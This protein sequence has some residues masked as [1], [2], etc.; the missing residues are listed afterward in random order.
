MIRTF[1]LNP[2]LFALPLVALA[3]SDTT[4][5]GHSSQTT[6][7]LAA[8]PTPLVDTYST[9]PFA[10]KYEQRKRAFIRLTLANPAQRTA[11][12]LLRLSLDL[13]IDESTI[14]TDLD[15]ID[16]RNDSADFRLASVLRLAYAYMDSDALS[17]SL[18]N[19]VR[20]TI[21]GFKY[22]PDEPGVDNMAYQTE[23]H[24][25]LFASAGLLA[26]KLYPDE[27]FTNAGNLG[28]DR[29]AVYQARVLRWLTLRQQTGFSEWLSNDYYNADA[30]ALLNLIDFSNDPEIARKATMVLD[31]LMMDMAQ[32]Q[33]QGSFASTHG[34]AKKNERFSGFN[35]VT[36]SIMKLQFGVNRF[37]IAERTT[38]FFVLSDYRLPR[39]I[40]D[41]ANDRRP[42][43]TKQRMGIKIEEA[44]RWGLDYGR[45]EDGMTF[46]T[47]EAYAHPL[48]VELFYR[49]LYTY[50]WWD[51]A[52]F[53]AF[54]Q[55]KDLLDCCS[56]FA[57]PPVCAPVAGLCAAGLVGLASGFERDVTRTMR[58]E[59]N[60]YTHRTRDYMLSTAQ[61]WRAGFGGDQ[62]AIVMAS[63]GPEATVFT[64]HPA[65]LDKSNSAITPTYWTGYGTLPRSA[66]IKN[67]AIEIYDIST[68][69]GLYLPSQML[70]TAAFVP[71]GKFDQVVERGGWIFVRKGAGFLA[72]W[73]RQPYVWQTN[74]DDAEMGGMYEIVA[75]GQ[76]NIWI[77]EAD[78]VGRYRSF[79]EF[80]SAIL[81]ASLHAT[82]SAVS[83]DSP[84]QGLLQ[85][86]SAGPLTQRGAAVSVSNYDRYQSRFSY[87]AFPGETFEFRHGQDSLVLDFANQARQVSRFVQ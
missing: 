10:R 60:I 34:R 33:F 71:R 6:S 51:N 84:S 19:R 78:R 9:R 35:D 40:Y 53:A 22:W 37:V 29:V 44:A 31:L 62:A 7:A 81:N 36:R 3:C 23:N 20:A 1:P 67:V 83:Y 45:L 13:P 32:H 28:R 77:L 27:I 43:T 12:E 63:L 24:F 72:L 73:S 38:T 85:F 69:P 64:T 2:G 18:K 56:V 66:Q 5:D 17:A 41:I 57:Q 86:G 80:R 47:F 52:Q 59:V 65:T 16:A 55:N 11:S 39:V 46:L 70:Q 76:R 21:L 79:A 75:P 49:M 74:P 30:A 82:E 25:I 87:A 54:Q 26:A 14:E 8:T 50:R 61:D 42:V 15:F 48:T 4:A 58:T 68:D